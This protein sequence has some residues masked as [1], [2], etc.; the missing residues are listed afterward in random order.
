MKTSNSDEETIHKEQI[1]DLLLKLL[2]IG[3]RD[4]KNSDNFDEDYKKR[5]KFQKKTDWKKFRASIDLLDDTEYALMSFFKYQ[6]GNLKNQNKD[7]GELYLRL[8][9]IL[10]AVYLQI[11]AYKQLSNLL[12]YPDRDKVKKKFEQLDIYKLRGIA[13]AHTVDYL[14]DKETLGKQK[15]INQT[16]SFR[17][18]Q[19]HLEETGSNIV[20]LDEN[21]ITFNFNLLYCLYEYE[22][23][24]TELLVNL[25]KHSIKTL[26]FDKETKTK[27]RE[28]LDE[29]MP[30]LIDY[31]KIDENKEYIEKKYKRIKRMF[32]RETKSKT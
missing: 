23:I 11:E 17:I 25:I 1:T 31:S 8:Y 12:N 7:T 32:E 19:M 5:L 20:A 21:N 26:I 15:N 2:E 9:G 27:M 18:V 4:I 29:L 24:A 13:G 30:N 22:R 3:G 16:T 14:Y 6:L 10:N 28:R